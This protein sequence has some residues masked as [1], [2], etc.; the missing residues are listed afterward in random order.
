ME[1]D[2]KLKFIFLC[3]METTHEPLYLDKLSLVWLWTYVQVL[4]Q[5]LFFEEVFKYGDGAKF[6]V[7][8]GQTLKHSVLN[9]AILCD[10]VSFKL[11]NLL[12]NAGK[13]CGLFFPELKCC[14]FIWK[15]C[16][17]S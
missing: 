6:V 15:N 11:F 4:F 12:N 1:Y 3:F 16:V 14:N 8:F 9:C 2:S 5:S 17:L 13:I 7:M 10:V